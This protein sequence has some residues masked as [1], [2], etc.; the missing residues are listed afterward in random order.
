MLV[1]VESS[2]EDAV[3]RLLASYITALLLPASPKAPLHRLL[4][5]LDRTAIQALDPRE[6]EWR[7]RVREVQ[8]AFWKMRF[9]RDDAIKRGLTLQLTE[10]RLQPGLFDR[11]AERCR[12]AA[13]GDVQRLI[14][15]LERRTAALAWCASHT[16]S[17]LRPLLV[18]VP[19]LPD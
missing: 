6:P 17:H 2:E 19:T 16:E 8:A 10:T 15:A 14:D 13:L 18:L 1:L 5:L 4:P 9:S 12:A 3:G 11:R 7:T